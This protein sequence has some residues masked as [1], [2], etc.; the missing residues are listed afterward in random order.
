MLSNLMTFG[1]DDSSSYFFG[2]SVLCPF[3]S[4]MHPWI[5][6][7]LLDF[8][9]SSSVE[10]FFDACPATRTALDLIPFISG[11]ELTKYRHRHDSVLVSN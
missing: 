3:D 6:H 4:F 7:D 11:C 5:T 1:N 10:H 9:R 8:T 2:S